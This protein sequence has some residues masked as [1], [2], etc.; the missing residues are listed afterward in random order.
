MS[1]FLHG[2]NF[3]LMENQS[4]FILIGVGVLLLSLHSLIWKVDFEFI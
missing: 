1:I 4:D 2:V 3:A